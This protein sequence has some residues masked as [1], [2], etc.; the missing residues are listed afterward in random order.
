MAAEFKIGR[1]R[2][3]WS[4]PW[5]TGVT[6]ARDN[7]IQY[8]G[9]VYVCLTPHTSTTFYTDINVLK[10]WNLIAEGKTWVGPW[11]SSTSY[12]LGNLVSYGGEIYTCATPNNDSTFT[13][14][15]WAT[16][17]LFDKWNNAWAPSYAY[18]VGDVVKYGG[19]VYRCNLNH[20]SATYTSPTY[21]GLENDQSKWTV[22]DAGYE[23]TGAW[24]T[25]TR[26][27][28]N[29]L[30]KVGPNVYQCST[31]HTSSSL[32]A[33][34]N[35]TMWIPGVE[36]VSTY[37]GSTYYQVGD[38]V[39][40]G[41]YNY[42]SKTSNN[43]SN[44]PSTDGGTNWTLLDT[45][46]GIKGVW[47]GGVSAKVGDIVQR[48]GQLF[49]ATA[50]NNSVDPSSAIILTTY[51]SSGSSGT[52]LKVASTSN[53]ATGMVLTGV[54]FTQGQTVV[55]VVDLVTVLL[56]AEPNG[57]PVNGQTLSFAGVTTSSWKLL[58][59]GNYWSNRWVLNSAYA[60]GDIVT[61]QNFT[62]SCVQNHTALSANRPD[63]DSNRTYWQYYIAQAQK[64]SSTSTGDL[65]YY[66]STTG[67]YT[68]LPI[69]TDG[70][71]LKVSS[72]TPSWAKLN[73]S[74]ALYYVASNG[75]DRSD[76]GTNWDQPWKTIQYAVGIL[77]NGTQNPNAI[78]LLTAN[79]S[80]ILAEMLQWA[81]Y[82]V[83]NNLTPF[84]TT[85]SLDQTKT[86]RDAGY[87]IDAIIYDIGRGGNSQ[88]VAAAT[89][90]FAYGST[91]TFFSTAVAVDVPFYLP[92]L[93]RLLTLITNALAQTSPSPSYQTLNNVPTPATQTTGVTAA[94]GT[95]STTV[96]SL[97][98][99]ITLS[100]TNQNT[101]YIPAAN[102]GLTATINVK[103]G[104][105]SETLPIIVPANVAINGDELRGVVV[106][107]A[108]S[109]TTIATSCSSTLITVVATTGMTANCPVQFSSTIGGLTAAT[110]Y[111][112]I[113][114]SIT[115][116]Q[117][118][119]SLTSGGATPISLTPTTNKSIIVY[120]GD[121]VKNMFLLRNGS[122][123][124][125][126]SLTGLLGF[127]QAA[128]TYGIQRPS[129]GAFA[130][131]DPGAGPT[132]TTA[133][134]FRRSPYCQNVSMFG[135]GCTGMKID[136]TLHN[137]GN[138]SI[139]ANDFTTIL[140]DGIGA[141]CTGSGSLTE[142]VSVFNYY[143]Y[144]GYFAENGGRMRATNG[145]SSY[146]T[147][148]CVALG[149]DL[150]EVAAT[151]IVFN[152]SQQIQA[153]VQSSLGS[154]S[155]L[156]KLNYVN[157]G[158]NYLTTT[159]NLLNYSN[160]FTAG[161]TTD[162]N[163]TLQ[164]NIIALTG[165][166]EAWTL[167]GT[168]SGTDGSY[169]YQN[170]AIPS[171]GGVYTN[172]PGTTIT[173]SG[174]SA[175]FDVTVTSTAYTVIV[176][177][178]GSNYATTNIINISGSVFG[179]IAGTNDLTLTVY[180]L[181]GSSITSVTVSGTVPSPAA[182]SY[183][184]SAYIYAGTSSNIDLYAIFSGSSSRTSSLNYNFTSGSKTPSSAN[185]GFLPINYGVQSTTVAG[186]YR[187]WMA[188]NDTTGQNTQLQFRIY[189]RGYSAGTA[190]QT[191]I[192][193]GAQVELS[194]S[195]FSPSFYLETQQTRYTSYANFQVVGSGSSASLLGDEIRTGNIFE[196]R[197][198]DSGFGAGGNGY[199]TAS[200][201][202]QAG[203]TG[204]ITLA[205][206][207][208]RLPSNYVTMRL[209]INS[210]TGAG[211][212]G[213][214]S[215]FNSTSKVAT[216]LRESFDVVPVGS[217]TTS[218]FTVV[219]NIS[220]LYSGLAI[221]FVPTYYTVLISGT[222]LGQQSVTSIQSTVINNSITSTL[223]VS[224][225]YAF[226]VNM[227]I[228]F[229]GTIF[230]SLTSGFTYYVQSIVDAT[231]ITVSTT[232][233]GTSIFL[234]TGTGSFTLNYP[235][236]TGALSGS[237]ITGSMIVNLPITFT[238]TALG[239]VSVGTAYYIQDV[240]NTDSF[241]ITSNL[242]TVTPTACST[243]AFTVASSTS[244]IP[245]NPIVFSGTV[246]GGGTI[247]AGQK[248]YISSLPNT[249]TFTV[250]SSLLTVTV[251]RTYSG[252][253]LIQIDQ[254]VAF[255][256]ANQPIIFYGNTFGGILKEHVYYIL[257]IDTGA[258]TF[259]ICDVAPNSQPYN[260][261]GVFPATGVMYARTCGSPVALT[262]TPS[263]SMTGTSSG[264]RFTLSQASGTMNGTFSTV[265]FGGVTQGTTYYVDT[266]SSTTVSIKD[267]S[268]API[269]LTASTGSMNIG[270]VGWDHV[271]PG[272]PILASLDNSSLYFIEPRLQYSDPAF[273]QTSA[274]APY[275]L[276][277]G[278]YVSM[279][280]G[281]GYFIAI[282]SAGAMA[283]RSLD[284]SSWTALSLPS[285]KSWTS[286]AYGAGYFVIIAGTTFSGDNSV[287]Y[288][289]N[290]GNGWRTA[291]LPLST[292]WKSVVYGNGIFAAVANGT[293][294]SAYSTDFGQTWSQ[295]A[296][297]GRKTATVVGTAKLSTTQKQFGATSLALNGTTDYISF[298]SSVDFALGTGDFTVECWVYRTTSPGV[299]QILFDFR[300]TSTNL[301]SPVVLLNSTYVPVLYVNGNTV[302]TGGA[303]VAL[304]T[305][306][307]I[308]ISRTS[309]STILWVNGTQSGST[310]TDANSYIQGPVILGA[311]P[312]GSTAFAG[313]IDE[314]RV[315]KGIGRYTATFTPATLA[316][317]PDSQ[318]ALLLNFDGLNNSTVITSS[319]L[320]TSIA[321]GSGTFVAIA[322]GSSAA[323][324]STDGITW[325]ASILPSSTAWSSITYGN[326][327]FVAVS[328]AVTSVASA[329]S[330]NGIT[331]YSASIP[332]TSN[333]VIYGQGTF[334]AVNSS[335]VNAYTSEEG[336]YWKLR[337]VSTSVYGAGAFGIISATSAGAFALLGDTS[338]GSNITAG[339]RAK[340][341]PSISTNVLNSISHWEPGSGYTM[342]P[343]LTITDPNV[344]VLAS[345]TP[346]L[347]NGS[348]GGPTFINRGTGYNNSSTV[349]TITGNGY[350]DAFQ[351]GY[352]IILNNM[353]RLPLVG[354][355]LTISGIPQIYKVTSASPMY[356][357]TA[358]NIEANVQISPT[359]TTL[360]SP[361]NG[362]TV[363]VRTKYSQVRLTGHDFLYIGTGNQAITNYPSGVSINNALAG[364]QTVELNYGRVFYTS[365]D[366]DGNFKV[367]TLFGV[368][369]ATGIVTL[370]ASQF[371][372]SGLS[373]LSL[374]GV[375]LGSSGVVIQGFSTDGTFTANT[376][377]VIPTQKA[378]KTYL[379]SRLTQGGANTT[380]GQL[381][382]GTILLGN[383]T[384]IASTIANGTAGSS[385]KMQSKVYIKA[386]GVDG[387]MAALDFFIRNA[388]RRSR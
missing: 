36:T 159:T 283:A 196:S 276:T 130:S 320:W 129:G 381:T 349:I 358:P 290:N 3:T 93:N 57:T 172:V 145:N 165:Y 362:T 228:N 235:T 189:P 271:N 384:F 53:L 249:T 326:G 237:G 367:G 248:Y 174:S 360:L 74:P 211:Q 264:N 58:V 245:M 359:M 136:G 120:G 234:T 229:T 117:F 85:Y 194:S 334:L 192:V 38:E 162:G 191:T 99:I 78:A 86:T 61:W 34:S 216:I 140:S 215:S 335:N 154:T 56:S 45:G 227:P 295:S 297:K 236:N 44:T 76:Y 353:S 366:Q 195:T 232:I 87:I 142:L 259:T 346:R 239:G 132:D 361:T 177:Q 303:A 357:T 9:K 267:V 113:G 59:S 385:I 317:V 263:G 252:S 279:A 373:T 372:L 128:D 14:S 246:F 157:A 288:S 97:F 347:G 6:Y 89:A 169:I 331:W 378:I 21:L 293:A 71:A 69:S 91:N 323:A 63:N 73:V 201:N 168:S 11:S 255:F 387:N 30:V 184:C 112:V 250:A 178:G 208:V 322:T 280:Y 48:N 65:Q 268:N 306:T 64:N 296:I 380:T 345:I 25:L 33:P 318:T 68:A 199:L 258:N 222:N 47:T 55:S 122:G 17:T 203:D 35:W 147:Y 309:G 307:H 164:K 180:S 200:N 379:T 355:N 158:N 269:T 350:S 242:I 383:A 274:A 376:D 23:Y 22:V 176:N 171:A 115:A 368:Q 330:F 253:N 292:N 98:S 52:T 219:S 209:F 50:D 167:T 342:T 370:S 313:Y 119:V 282:P 240:I 138:K 205:Q 231:T 150:S 285:A 364:N 247:T 256:V 324:Y 300:T 155:Q 96:N 100:L 175:T 375:A 187:M 133:W 144:M 329:Y 28:Q 221:Q 336:L 13:S 377:S 308:A 107:P 118:S 244:L 277:L 343:T 197:V 67:K 166:T 151:G 388:S 212:Y 363:S 109:I 90:Y 31:Y 49:I 60:V 121:A 202:A 386:S 291:T 7:V 37:S 182:Q 42:V 32:F 262:N 160:L 41:G 265:L 16:W 123:L 153:S 39:S 286:I 225:A 110:T 1:L 356:G 156:V 83:A 127:L 226:Y 82:Q 374:G 134:I 101:S 126:L 305:W 80:W 254:S 139:V 266:V 365:T 294:Y 149:F 218:A 81:I 88:T 241:T 344:T 338:T 27:K 319:E 371:G 179:G 92:I 238:G 146:G 141:W 337:T 348:L 46:Y 124:R 51:T 275:T 148:G 220:N 328:S 230:T 333:L 137:G 94:E 54:G 315:S 321:Y 95:A 206:S 102:A 204:Q 273:T 190:N 278:T 341:R 299:N 261:S 104:T 125:N 207:D 43:Y 382:A 62:Y 105:Y 214:I 183:T 143:G 302:I 339:V 188:V 327:R 4:G 70:Y 217:C 351:T 12:A 181:S 289:A 161:W 260:L 233:S 304:T 84:S 270:A 170:I 210:G 72:T 281:A 298:P 5:N 24:T 325:T 251:N 135:I 29:D 185:G 2:F 66:S 114:S 272:T 8:N 75:I 311:Q 314:F 116:T 213:Y 284:G 312:D 103:T 79:K 316:F 163:V 224:N 152:R 77:K 198:I 26:Y 18:G 19:I 257:A 15:K 173:G 354:D 332:F 106:Q 186:W 131:L 193:Y 108:V 301:V 369:Q 20:V 310:Y 10:Y 223:T 243:T 287:L 40:Y 352:T 111:Y 340:G